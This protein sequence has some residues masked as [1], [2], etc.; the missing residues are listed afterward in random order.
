MTLSKP[1]SSLDTLEKVTADTVS[2]SEQSTLLEGTVMLKSFE[3]KQ[4]E[5]LSG[6][7]HLYRA[8]SGTVLFREGDRSDFMCLVLQGRVEVSKE[9]AHHDFKTVAV[10]AAGRSLGEMAMVDHEPRSATARV[11]EEALLAV[12]T[13]QGFSALTRDKPALAVQ[14]LLKV[15]QLISQRLRHASGVLVDYLEK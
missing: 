7:F 6:Y 12:L 10:V 3:W 14:L 13:Q 15:A 2:M 1:S 11:T 9:D 5:A 8:V 4:I